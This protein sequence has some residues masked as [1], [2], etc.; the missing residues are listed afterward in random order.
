MTPKY[1]N[2]WLR[3]IEEM[4]ST[5]DYK[6]T[7]GKAIIECITNNKYI[8]EDGKYI[9]LFD[10]ISKFMINYYWDSLFYTNLKHGTPRRVLICEHVNNLIEKYKT[11]TG[12]STPVGYEKGINIIKE[13]DTKF[14]NDIV[15]SVSKV[16]NT[17]VCKAFKNVDKESLDMYEYNN[18]N[19]IKI[20]KEDAILL[21]E[22]KEL[23]IKKLDDKFKQLLDD[24]NK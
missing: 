21:N 18:K 1:I 17:C 10:D 22:Y 11:I 7:W 13:K 5:T 19:N 4:S 3:I 14:Y 15:K 8:E 20:K 2:D 6:V 23:L 24:F 16:L 9:I 12:L